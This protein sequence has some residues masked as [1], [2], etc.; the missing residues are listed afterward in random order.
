[1]LKGINPLLT[2]EL[3][4]RLAQTGHN[5]WVAVVDANFTAELLAG[6]KRVIRLPGITLVDACA[7]IISVFPICN[8]VPHPAGYMH[9]S[10]TAPT[11]RT[12]AQ[13][14]LVGL[15]EREYPAVTGKIEAI[16]RFAFYERAKQA[17]IIV[18]CGETSAYGNALLCKDVILP[19]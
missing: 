16:E 9:A 8:D 7:A 2:P 6:G 3:L 18:Q 13:Q 12:P 15:I 19:D 1:M 4:M 10:G 14:A 17:S 11:H 5:E